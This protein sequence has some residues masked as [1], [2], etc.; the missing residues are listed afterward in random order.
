MPRHWTWFF[1]SMGLFA[2]SIYNAIALKYLQKNKWSKTPS[3]VY[4]YL[5]NNGGRL[6]FLSC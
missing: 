2:T 6:F 4:Y 5:N 1:F 3:L